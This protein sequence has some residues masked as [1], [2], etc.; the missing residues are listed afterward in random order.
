MQRDGRLRVACVEGVVIMRTVLF[1]CT[2]NRLRSPTAEQVDD[3][4]Y[5]EP[6][7]VALLLKKVSPFL[8][9]RSA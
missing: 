1:I 9:A 8:P 3:Y 6:A 4:K 7:L 2:Q 5:M